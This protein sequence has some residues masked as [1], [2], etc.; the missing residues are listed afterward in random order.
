MPSFAASLTYVPATESK[1][2][3]ELYLFGGLNKDHVPHNDLWRFNLETRSWLHISPVISKSAKLNEHNGIPERRE[4]H[5]SCFWTG[6]QGNSRKLVVFGGM[7]VRKKGK[8]KERTRLNDIVIYDIDKNQWEFQSKL[9]DV[10]PKGRSLHSALILQN[11]LI[12]FGGWTVYHRKSS[13]Q[14]SLQS[15]H[16]ISSSNSG[17]IL[18]SLP[19]IVKKNFG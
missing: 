7:T 5:S 3:A 17:S 15:L 14:K 2:D 12:V 6:N 18:V 1:N 13:E 4:G 11:K 16:S 10:G 19:Q 8:E 9:S